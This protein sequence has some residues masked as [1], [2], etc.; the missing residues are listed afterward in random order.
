[1][2]PVGV[3]KTC[4]PVF[5]IN[6]QNLYAR[7]LKSVNRAAVAESMEALQLMVRDI[8]ALKN[9]AQQKRTHLYVFS[10]KSRYH[11]NVIESRVISAYFPQI[12]CDEL[13][14]KMFTCAIAAAQEGV[15]YGEERERESFTWN[16]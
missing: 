8:S 1:M 15:N 16:L 7:S 14:N 13:V 5:S 6:V 11:E 9:R 12:Y 10:Q 3:K 2:L 4:T